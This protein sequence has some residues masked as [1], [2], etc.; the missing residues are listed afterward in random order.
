MAESIYVMSKISGAQELPKVVQWTRTGLV[1]KNWGSYESFEALVFSS[2]LAAQIQKLAL[3]LLS[4]QEICAKARV[5]WRRGAFV[6]GPAGG[7]K[8]AVTRAAA[9]LLGWRHITILGAEIL[10]V[11]HL[12]R[13]LNESSATSHAVIVIENID[14]I[15]Q[16]IDP[17]V[18]LDIFD[19]VSNRREGI[20]WV[21]TTRRP[22]D[23]P[24]IQLV[25]PG[26][27]DDSLRVAYPNAETKRKYYE[28][29]I[30]PI[31]TDLGIDPA[32]AKQEHLSVLETNDQLSFAHLE[33]MRSLLVR[34]LMDGDSAKVSQELST[35]CQ[36]QVIGFNRWGGRTDQA[37]ELEERVRHTDPRHLLSALEVT[38]AFKRVIELTVGSAAEALIAAE[39]QK[40]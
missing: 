19:D 17:S 27:F 35:Y 28:T 4:A 32:L 36:E 30:E 13:A 5:P 6:W 38:D 22:E 14:Q 37:L 18:F 20:F 34:V 26:R 12:T 11:H 1:Q 24:K 33:E 9:L 21:A 39:E 25:R 40:G 8:T 2:G 7:G 31:M 29:Y 15:L 10:D 16:R 23:V 3:G